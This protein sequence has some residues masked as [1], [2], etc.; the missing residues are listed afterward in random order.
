MYAIRTCTIVALVLLLAGTA[1]GQY[2]PVPLYLDGDN[3]PG[4]IGILDNVD[5]PNVSS[6]GILGLTV[7]GVRGRH[8]RAARR[9]PEGS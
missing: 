9:S 2:F 3:A 6:A 5:R 8:L 1:F 7:S 4:G